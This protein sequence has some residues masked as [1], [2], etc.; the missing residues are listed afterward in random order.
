MAG[1]FSHP[2]AKALLTEV[3]AIFT[4]RRI[5]RTKKRHIVFVCGGPVGENANSLRKKFLSWARTN[6]PLGVTLLLAEEAF[7]RTNLYDPPVAVNLSKFEKTIGDIS[8]C[9]I[10]FPESPGS[11]AEI[12]V[13]S[14][15]PNIR[16]KTLVVN[17]LEFQTER[18][19]TN[20]GPIKVIGSESAHGPVYLVTDQLE[21]DFSP[22]GERL[23]QMFARAQRRRFYYRRFSDLDYGNKLIV[24]L[25]LVNIFRLITLR[26]IVEATRNIF[27]TASEKETSDFLSILLAAG[28]VIHRD[29]FFAPKKEEVSFFEYD[30]FEIDRQKASIIQYYQRYEKETFRLLAELDQ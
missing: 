23:Q 18:S 8:D 14:Q 26:G 5:Y 7:E 27:Q 9:I 6:L 20:L 11:F 28:Y 25:E 3:S 13:F 30:G 17:G 10:M 15:I 16:R 21:I 12:G 29:D 24:I 1:Y 4:Q 2:T 19:F 22:V